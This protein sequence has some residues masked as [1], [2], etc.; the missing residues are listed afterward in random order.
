MV[1]SGGVAEGLG[2][3]PGAR[4]G[5]HGVRVW[6]VGMCRLSEGHGMARGGC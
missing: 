3:G 5:Y 4:W 6:W 1:R 2:A